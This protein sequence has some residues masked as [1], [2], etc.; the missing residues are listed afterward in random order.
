MAAATGS[1]P[2][3]LTMASKSKAIW[4]VLSESMAAAGPSALGK[5]V[6]I[7][8][9]A[10]DTAS[11]APHEGFHRPACRSRPLPILYRRGPAARRPRVNATG[12]KGGAAAANCLLRSLL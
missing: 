10:A 5:H 11:A 4:M 2:P 7:I 8:R 3:R 1:I 12:E 9:N 6:V